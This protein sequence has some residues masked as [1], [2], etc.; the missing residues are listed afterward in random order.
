MV[1]QISAPSI[2]RPAAERPQRLI[3]RSFQC[4]GDIVVMTA[5]VRELH[6][7]YAEKYETDVRTSVPA[8]WEHNPHITAIA[9]TDPEARPIDMHYPLVN[10]SNQRPVHFLDGYCEFL[11]GQLGLPTLRPFEFR[12]HIY[13]S[14]DEQSWMNQVQ[15]VTGYRGRFWLVNAGSKRDFTCKQWPLEYFQDVID[16]LRGRIVFVQIGAAE[17]G[18]PA[19]DGVIDLRGKT[20]HRQLIRLVYHSSGVLTGVSYPMHLAAAVP[21]PASFARVRPCVVV[22]GGREPPHWE[23][24]PGHQLLH[25]IGALSC[26]STGGCWKSRVVPLGD[27]DDKDRELCLQPLA[28]H[29]RCMWILT[30]DDVIRAIDRYRDGD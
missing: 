4:P 14:A 3:L 17:H 13:L 28:G 18:H 1:A 25:T 29:P 21:T 11:A 7:Q 19:L 5:A 23:Q 22:N 12:G 24:Y 15:E 9:D 2:Q 10:H 20:D 16:R 27:G 8:I 6:R 30:P 26:C